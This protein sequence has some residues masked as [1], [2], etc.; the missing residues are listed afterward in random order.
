MIL[1]HCTA[2]RS[3]RSAAL[4]VR[5]T[6]LASWSPAARQ[7]LS[8]LAWPDASIRATHSLQASRERTT[9]Q[10]AR[11]RD[12]CPDVPILRFA[13]ARVLQLRGAIEFGEEVT[14]AD[15]RPALGKIDD[16]E[17]TAGGATAGNPRRGEEL[18]SGGDSMRP[19][20]RMTV[21]G[22]AAIVAYGLPVNVATARAVGT[23][24]FRMLALRP[25]AISA[26]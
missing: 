13:V 24:D 4:L 14:L 3:A 1:R 15:D 9:N 23:R 2:V 17:L 25:T 12:L 22:G 20:R 10:R 26:S 11:E 16:D 18:G 21:S 8:P 19:L 7:A 6:P 5:S